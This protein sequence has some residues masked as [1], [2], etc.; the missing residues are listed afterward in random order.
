MNKE[1]ENLSKE[2]IK[3]S[4][5]KFRRIQNDK[6]ND[7]KKNSIEDI[8]SFND[9]K[10]E[11]KKNNSNHELEPLNNKE[12]TK[13]KEAT[14]FKDNF[15]LNSLYISNNDINK[16]DN[17]VEVKNENELIS[18]CDKSD[19]NSFNNEIIYKEKDISNSDIT[20]KDNKEEN[21]LKT[22]VIKNKIIIEDNQ[23]INNNKIVN[24]NIKYNGDV[25]ISPEVKKIDKKQT[26]NSS[27]FKYNLPLEN[28]KIPVIQCTFENDNVEN[29]ENKNI[30]LNNS[31][32]LDNDNID[33]EIINKCKMNNRNFFCLKKNNITY[34]KKKVKRNNT[35]KI[36]RNYKI[37]PLQETKN[38]EEIKKDV[39]SIEKGVNEINIK[40]NILNSY[41]NYNYVKRK[42]KNYTINNSLE[43]SKNND[44]IF[45]DRIN[46]NTISPRK[47][48]KLI[49]KEVKI[50]P[51]E[52]KNDDQQIKT[53]NL[54]QINCFSSRENC[55]QPNIPLDLDSELMNQRN[56][57]CEN[58]IIK[59]KINNLMNNQRNQKN[60]K[61]LI[62]SFE[63]N[64]TIGNFKFKKTKENDENSIK[65]I[66]KERNSYHR[67]NSSILH[68]DNNS[69]K[70]IY[71]KSSKNIINNNKKNNNNNHTRNINKAIF[72]GV[73]E[74][75]NN[76][77]YN[78][79]NFE[80]N[81]LKKI[82]KISHIQFKPKIQLKNSIPMNKLSNRKKRFNYNQF[83]KD[84]NQFYLKKANNNN[85]NNQ[86]YNKMYNTNNNS[87]YLPN[88]KKDKNK[89]NIQFKSNK[90]YTSNSTYNKPNNLIFN[91]HNNKNVA[92]A[93]TIND[94]DNYH[95]NT[96][97]NINQNFI[98]IN[99]NSNKSIANNNYINNNNS[100]HSLLHVKRNSKLNKIKMKTNIINKHHKMITSPSL[101][102]HLNQNNNYWK[103]YKKPKNC[104]LLNKFS[105]D[106]NKFDRINTDYN[107]GN[108]QFIK[109]KNK[110][111]INYN[112]FSEENNSTIINEYFNIRNNNHKMTDNINDN[113]KVEQ[114]KEELNNTQKSNL[115]QIYHNYN[116]VNRRK[117]SFRNNS[118]E[119]REFIGE[120]Q[121]TFQNETLLKLS[122]LRN[123]TNNK[124]IKEF[125]VVVGEEK[126]KKE[127]YKS[128]RISI[129]ENKIIKNNDNLNNLNDNKK[130]I[131]TFNQYYPSYY[132]NANDILKNEN[133]NI[134]NNNRI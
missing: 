78:T 81:E 91:N 99:N 16:I 98:L 44:N 93:E 108:S 106:N 45:S 67:E 79:I 95:C 21:D 88:N 74:I 31:L 37:L 8:F 35:E 15:S 17:N 4:T 56:S 102:S 43:R 90:I 130:T 75:K 133:N 64:N 14:V 87:K 101:T 85:N 30:N 65:N 89:F 94:N 82:P 60:K 61:K 52:N 22:D 28:D 80:K 72:N 13:E 59:R 40:K 105:N 97:R 9:S 62:K 118:N 128:E 104:C 119:N 29:D 1:N 47:K 34:S 84:K 122:I 113:I 51:N 54:N 36:S 33:N 18:F 50:K 58:I 69:K 32:D 53:E 77:L 129:K 71:K 39:N 27:P 19:N 2:S 83:K 25:C 6:E 48:L 126:Y 121:N 107:R 73:K 92:K 76:I 24:N 46:Y 123:N 5:P 124:I 70:L 66:T 112:H 120:D 3:L 115:K 10:Y 42:I 23:K 134:E 86:G 109:F 20:I 96:D 111:P 11:T 110:I 114:E 49:I 12:E 38:E 63:F 68:K 132:I 116:K 117:N 55:D 100:S 57:D 127:N 125:S 131:I 103:I 7:S 41:S 26:N